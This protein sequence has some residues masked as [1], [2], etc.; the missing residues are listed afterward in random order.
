MKTL[1]LTKPVQTRNGLPA[2][3]LITDFKHKEYT[4]AAAVTKDG[5]EQLYTYDKTG[6]FMHECRHELDLI[7]IPVEITKTSWLNVYSNDLLIDCLHSTRE[8]ADMQACD[9]RIACIPVTYTYTEGE[10]LPCES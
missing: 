8:Q 4:V 10:G 3:I 6:R 7:N 1:D 2:R 5:K 9:G